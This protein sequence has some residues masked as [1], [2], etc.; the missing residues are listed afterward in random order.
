MSWLIIFIILDEVEISFFDIDNSARPL[1]Y[2]LLLLIFL[3]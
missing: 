1:K 2:K 3:Q